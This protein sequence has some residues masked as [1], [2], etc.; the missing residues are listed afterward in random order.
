[1][2]ATT[3]NTAC[4]DDG[5][6]GAAQACANKDIPGSQTPHL[7]ITKSATAQTYSKAGDVIHLHDRRDQ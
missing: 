6:G 1:M 7:S 2:P 3:L 5:Q 4:V